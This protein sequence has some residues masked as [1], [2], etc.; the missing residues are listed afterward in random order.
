MVDKSI[1]VASVEVI[2][3]SSEAIDTKVTC[4]IQM[5]FSSGDASQ[6]AKACMDCR[7]EYQD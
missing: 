4:L 7:R 3:V 1:N 5:V 6:Y 2:L